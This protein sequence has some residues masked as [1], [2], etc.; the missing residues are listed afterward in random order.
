MLSK[1]ANRLDKPIRKVGS[2]VGLKL[3]NMEEVARERVLTNL[4]SIMD[5][6]VACIIVFIVL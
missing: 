1:D 6:D 5:I 2:T 3:A 4:L